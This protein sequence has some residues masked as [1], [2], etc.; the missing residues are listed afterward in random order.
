MKAFKDLTSR[1]QVRRIRPMAT[2]LLEKHRRPYDSLKLIHHGENTTFRAKYKGQNYL[3]RIHRP[4]YQTLE[5]IRSEM[6]FIEH[7]RAF[8]LN[9]PKP[10]AIADEPISSAVQLLDAP[11]VADRFGVLFN[12]IQGRIQEKSS[13]KSAAKVGAFMA[14]MHLASEAFN[15]SESFFR[16]LLDS[17]GLYKIMGGDVSVFSK[18]DQELI[19]TVQKQANA[20]LEEI[21]QGKKSFGMVHCD[22]HAGNRLVQNGE[23][24]AIDFDDCGWSWFI[25]DIA[26]CLSYHQSQADHEEL[27]HLFFEGYRSVRPISE[28]EEE[29]LDLLIQVRYIQILLW[30][31]GRSDNPSF[32]KRLPKYV[33]YTRDALTEFLDKSR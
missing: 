11:N 18:S 12:W 27:T 30:I 10:I 23:V 33:E 29:S 14:K 22:F 20:R 19:A 31:Q 5:T 28:F 9:V 7:Y 8:G 4:G 2:S 25:Y 17:Q 1:G 3:C 15:P 32:V 24:A 16:P 26:V 21:G 6:E 13:K